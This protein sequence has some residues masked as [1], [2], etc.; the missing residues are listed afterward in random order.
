MLPPCWKHT[1][2]GPHLPQQLLR[3]NTTGP[4]LPSCTHRTLQAP[5]PPRPYG[6]GPCRPH[7]HRGYTGWDPVVPTATEAIQDGTLSS[8]QPPRLYR[9][10]PCSPHSHRGHTDGTLQSPQPPRLRI[11][12]GTLRLSS[13]RGCPKLRLLQRPRLFTSGS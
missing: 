11:A 4:H 6:M 5:Q 3:L 12:N 8:P 9:M 2:A 10:G 13:H 1:Q 7:S